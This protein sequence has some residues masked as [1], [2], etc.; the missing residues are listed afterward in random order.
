MCVELVYRVKKSY[1]FNVDPFFR[2]LKHL[3]QK[4]YINSPYLNITSFEI[5]FWFVGF[6]PPS[7]AIR[8]IKH[9]VRIFDEEITIKSKVLNEIAHNFLF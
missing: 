1:A 2:G 7:G 5:L 9:E 6:P 8:A 4:R 3:R